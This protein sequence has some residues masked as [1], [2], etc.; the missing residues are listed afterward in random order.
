MLRLGIIG[1]GL[2]AEKRL[3]P[4]LQRC[5]SV[6]LVALS[7]RDAAL[8][9]GSAAKHGVAHA[10][11]SAEEL[12]RCQEVDAVFVATPN[13]LHCP[14][15]LTAIAHRKPVL[16][17]KP[18]AMNAAECESMVK[19]A[20]EAGVALGVAQVFRFARSVQRTREWVAA[21]E[22]GRP[23]LARAEFTYPGIGHAR[24]W[25]HNRAIGGGATADVGVHC[26]DAL[27][28]ILHDEV[29]EV[30]GRAAFDLYSQQ[31]DASAALVLRFAQGTLGTVGVSMRTGY[32]TA[33]E[34]IGENGVVRAENGLALDLP[35]RI[36]LLR[37]GSLVRAEDV[38]NGDAFVRQ[39]DAFAAAVEGRG[40]FPCPGEE[41]WRNQ[42][43]LDAAY[44]KLGEVAKFDLVK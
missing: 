29:A 30:D 7:R 32:R 13:V 37:Q 11:S 27:R 33:V 16:C 14:D 42:M 10:F 4:A 19:A 1:F 9:Q 8:A 40:E 5:R 39:F 44:A 22:V 28:F 18:M 43:V 21:G 20:R 15:T 34:V 24:T 2:H 25:I 23:V 6:R 41:G 26:I 3:V 31:T 17:E 36:E 35:V 38:S 12:C